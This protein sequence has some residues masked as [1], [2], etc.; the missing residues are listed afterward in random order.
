MVR[1]TVAELAMLS[2]GMVVRAD[3]RDSKGH[4]SGKV[5]PA[6]IVSN[7]FFNRNLL[8]VVVVVISSLKLPK[9]RRFEILIP[10]GVGG[11]TVDSVAQPAS[12]IYTVSKSE[13]IFEILGS[14]PDHTMLEIRAALLL[15]LS[16]ESLLVG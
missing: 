15:V 4:E 1:P 5:R 6:V 8:T 10:A 16:N 11:L 3:L 2:R 9:P 7:D 13:R 12:Q 14:L